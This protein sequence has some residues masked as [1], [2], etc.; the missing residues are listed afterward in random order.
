[1][2]H[3]IRTPLHQV[4]GFIELLASSPLNGE[5]KESVDMLQSSTHALMAIINDLLDFTKLEAGKMK[6]EIIPFEV[7]GV[8][9]GSVAAVQ[10]QVNER[11]L[12]IQCNVDSNIPIKM[13]GDPNR[14]RQVVLNMLTNAVKF[15]KGG[16]IVVEGK[17]IEKKDENNDDKIIAV[18]FTVKDTGVGIP[19]DKCDRIFNPY[20]QADASVSRNYGGTGLGLAICK[21]LVQNSMGGTIGVESEVGKGTTFW[22]EIPFGTFVKRQTNP[23]VLVS[24]SIDGDSTHSV[25][26]LSTFKVLVAE[27]NKAS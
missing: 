22:F 15:T 1:M 4:V 9:N 14:L 3:E 12:S 8:L 26:E 18:R 19:K 16:R 25:E 27:D 17:R 6:L 13:L 23:K 10:P 21:S 2:A 20:Q 7:R 11:G 24:D 5:Q